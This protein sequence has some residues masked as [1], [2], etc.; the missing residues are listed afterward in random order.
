MNKHILTGIMGLLLAFGSPAV[1]AENYISLKFS[2]AGNSAA[3]SDVNTWIHS[4]NRLWSDWHQSHG[5]Q[6]QGEFTPLDYQGS[7]EIELR[8]PLFSGAALNMAGS[9][10]TA[11]GQGHVE[12]INPS[13]NLMETQFIS[14]KVSVLPL[15]IGLSYTRPIP[16]LEGLYVTAQAGRH[17]IFYQYDLQD[18]Y[19]AQITQGPNIYEYG[20][21]KNQS[22]RS[23]GLGFYFSL[24]LEFDIIRYVAVVLEGE[25]V[26]STTDGFKGSHSYQ[27]Y[28]GGDPFSESGKASLYY[29]ESSQWNLGRYYS[30]LTGHTRPPDRPDIK[31]LRQGEFNFDNF[32]IK[33]GIRFKF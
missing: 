7:L 26:W 2:Y 6:L 11:S 17:I 24:G 20:Y 21:E 18:H 5:G 14:N 8:I 30:V 25:Q 9:G 27:G 28:L 33:L 12:F 23:E 10:L 32:S 1:K 29:Y 3:P 13:G 15:K 4:Y 22:F 31:N 19:T 16:Y